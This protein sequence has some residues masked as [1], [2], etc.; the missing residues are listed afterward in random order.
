MS[1]AKEQ[2]T[3]FQKSRFLNIKGQL[4][5]FGQPK[6]MGILNMTPDSFYE[7][8]RVLEQSQLL[9][10]AHAMITA[11]ADILDL[12]ASSTRPDAPINSP[13]EEM[14]RLADNIQLLKKAFP[15]TLLSL[16][17]YYGAVAQFGIAQG[18][19]LINDISAGQFDPTLWPVVAE[20]KIPYILNY[21]RA[22]QNNS[23]QSFLK[24][25]GIVSDALSFLSEKR[26]ALQALGCT[27]VLIDPGF[28]FGK[29]LAENH[30][31]LHKLE[32]LHLLG[33]PLLIGVSR[34]SMI[35]KVLNCTAQDALNGT[36]ILNTLA[37]SK[38]A[39]I[40]RVHDIA[41][42]REMILLLAAQDLH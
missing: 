8:S 37:Y 10:R 40:F 38:G 32:H 16:D 12:G 9:E 33:A 15:D 7:K 27:D 13:Q 5:D 29:S 30:E 42:V 35:T 3:V 19:D 20:A 18:I 36:S 39:R 21:N 34:K 41:A 1:Q 17:T 11:G 14:D 6:I 23:A 28:G 4:H 22:Q 31:L 25:K 2:S 24:E 26:A